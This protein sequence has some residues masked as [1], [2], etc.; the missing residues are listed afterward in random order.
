MALGWV[1]NGR[2]FGEDIAAEF[3]P[4]RYPEL[5]KTCDTHIYLNEM[6][7][8]SKRIQDWLQEKNVKAELLSFEESVHSVED[9]MVATGFPVERISKSIVMMTS[10]ANLII[11]MVPAE[12]RASTERVRKF[13]GL[14]ERPRMATPEEIEMQ[15]GQQVGGNSPF[16]SPKARILIDPKLLEKD[17][18][19]TGGGDDK[20]LVKISIEELKRVIDYTEARV[21]R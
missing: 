6:T 20:H 19:V 17:W 7:K 8:Y 18:V 12:N 16:N 5:S 2:H 3:V 9:T 1:K 4:S 14:D 13:L 21:R 15:T 11:A 10:T